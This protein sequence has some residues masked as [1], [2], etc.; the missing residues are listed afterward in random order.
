MTQ[1]RYGEFQPLHSLH[2]Y[3]M[4][5]P[6]CTPPPPPCPQPR[7]TVWTRLKPFWSDHGPLHGM[8]DWTRSIL[9]LPWTGMVPVPKTSIH[10]LNFEILGGYLLVPG[11]IGMQIGTFQFSPSLVQFTGYCPV[12]LS[13]AYCPVL[14]YFVCLSLELVF[15]FLTPSLNWN[16]DSP[17]TASCCICCPLP[18]SISP[19]PHLLFLLVCSSPPPPHATTTVTLSQCQP[20]WGCTICWYASMYQIHAGLSIRV[21]NWNFRPCLLVWNFSM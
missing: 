11:W 3:C 9:A 12:T 6:A 16:V 20:V 2:A 15:N 13:W 10:G 18:S 1:L 5:P 19:L 17:H 7:P 8:L 21:C 14:S 4:W